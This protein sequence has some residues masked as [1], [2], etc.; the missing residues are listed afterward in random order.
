VRQDG[1]E[2]TGHANYAPA[3]E[4]IVC[5]AVSALWQTLIESIE[6]LTDDRIEYDVEGEQITNL[7]YRNPSDRTRALIDS[8]FIGVNMIANEYPDCVR[9]V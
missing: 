7:Y 8:F 4:D 2:V 3:G 9:I 6:A 1:I 5:A